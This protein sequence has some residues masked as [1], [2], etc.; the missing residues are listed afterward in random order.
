MFCM[1]EGV[2]VDESNIQYE[3]CP[4]LYTF[5]RGAYKPVKPPPTH[6][7]SGIEN[8]HHSRSHNQRFCSR[9]KRGCVGW[10]GPRQPPLRKRSVRSHP[11]LSLLLVCCVSCG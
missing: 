2:V 1:S 5:R 3:V 11:V 9:N 4:P 6:S 7:Q 10:N 8:S